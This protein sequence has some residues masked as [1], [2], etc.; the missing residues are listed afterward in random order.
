LN[1]DEI[2]SELTLSK[3]NKLILIF[4]WITD[5][6]LRLVSMFPEFMAF[7][8]TCQTNRE[9]RNMFIGCSK[10]G[11]NNGFHRFHAFDVY[12][13]LVGELNFYTK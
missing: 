11:N 10:D 4:V 3:E 6:E 5:E 13:S 12:P 9:R 8:V 1:A 2:R 7:D